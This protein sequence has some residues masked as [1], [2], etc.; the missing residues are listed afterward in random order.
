MKPYACLC[1]TF[2]LLFTAPA[3]GE[4]STLCCLGTGDQMIHNSN[5]AGHTSGKFSGSLYLAVSE[6]QVLPEILQVKNLKAKNQEG[7]ET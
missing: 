1:S 2:L 3:F 4:V 5:G 6:D 7:Q